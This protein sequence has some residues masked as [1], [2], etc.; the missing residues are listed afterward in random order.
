MTKHHCSSLGKL[1]FEQ[2]LINWVYLYGE[3]NL[4][5]PLLKTVVYFMKIKTEVKK[6]KKAQP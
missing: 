1:I 6:K 5:L 3:K 4:T 2:Y